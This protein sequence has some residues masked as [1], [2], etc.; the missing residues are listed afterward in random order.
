MAIGEFDPL[1]AVGKP[2]IPPVRKLAICPKCNKRPKLKGEATCFECL[3]V[4]ELERAI[5]EPDPDDE[6][7]EQRVERLEAVTQR[8][9]EEAAPIPAQ[10]ESDMSRKPETFTCRI[11]CGRDLT[12][13]GRRA[14]HELK[15][16][17]KQATSGR[18]AERQKALV[19]AG[20][21]RRTSAPAKSRKARAR[22][23][24]VRAG[25]GH[26]TPPGA[27][28]QIAAAATDKAMEI[29][30]AGLMAKRTAIDNA[31][32]ALQAVS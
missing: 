24:A 1:D 4:D 7:L 11:G 15:C 9:G 28:A 12:S 8:S 16:K 22:K 21:S 19:P 2:R 18:I 14:Q 6:D 31:I 27:V 13:E 30:I 25:D 20:T 23:V 17:G 10:K 32:A 26:R 3:D 5:A 29:V